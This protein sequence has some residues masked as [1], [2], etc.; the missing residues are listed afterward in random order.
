VVNL[1]YLEEVIENLISILSSICNLRVLFSIESLFKCTIRG[2]IA[3]SLKFLKGLVYDRETCWVQ[4]TENRVYE[5]WK[6]NNTVSIS[7][8]AGEDSLDVVLFKVKLEIYESLL[9]LLVL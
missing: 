6:R 2:N 3:G 4:L 9:K 5:F 1:E 7:V 8:K